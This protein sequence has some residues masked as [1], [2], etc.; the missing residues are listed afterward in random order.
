MITLT[1]IYILNVQYSNF[2]QYDAFGSREHLFFCYIDRL[3]IV[4]D[5]FSGALSTG[6]E[7]TQLTSSGTGRLLNRRTTES[8]TETSGVAN[9][10]TQQRITPNL[11]RM[12]NQ[13]TVNPFSITYPPT[14]PQPTNN[15]HIPTI[16]PAQT[17]RQSR[18][19][20]TVVPNTPETT[21]VT[22]PILPQRVT[23]ASTTLTP[24]PPRDSTSTTPVAPRT[25]AT[26]AV[27]G[28]PFTITWPPAGDG[29]QSG[30]IT[31]RSTNS[32][33]SLTRRVSRQELRRLGRSDRDT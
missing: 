8:H 31:H 12:S 6:T 32:T 10:Y 1:L 3:V 5:I 20:P 14:N 33:T 2:L 21:R 9:S 11:V 26:N 22:T 13:E 24:C 17:I 16:S 4:G 7:S 29:V 15:R 19:M 28:N 18:Q 30:G 23:G 27:S 25:G